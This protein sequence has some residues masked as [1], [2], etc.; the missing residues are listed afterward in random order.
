MSEQQYIP[1]QIVI[2]EKIRK[3]ERN[4][5]LRKSSWLN[6]FEETVPTRLSPDMKKEESK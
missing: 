4:W 1:D 5:A 3:E 2:G 6:E